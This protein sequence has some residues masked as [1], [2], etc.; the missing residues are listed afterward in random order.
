MRWM[1]LILLA[2]VTS[3][4][5]PVFA[6]PTEEVR[7]RFDGFVA[8]QNA[9]D[10]AA[11]RGFLAEGPEFV[12]ITRGQVIEGP[13]AAL[14]RFSSLYQGTWRLDP[15]SQVRTYVVAPDIVQLVAPVTFRIGPPGQPA[16]ETLFLLTQLWRRTPS[17]WRIESLLP[18]PSAAR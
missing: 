6:G 2:G 4:A 13:E 8:A 10:L 16:S 18:I 5:A 12:W 14:D 9:H 17:G 1:A 11:V 15:A 3:A 7:T